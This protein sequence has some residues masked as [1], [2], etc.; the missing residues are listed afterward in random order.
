MAVAAVGEGVVVLVAVPGAGVVVRRAPLAHLASAPALLWLDDEEA[1]VE[2]VHLVSDGR[3]A[4]ALLDGGREVR[5]LRLRPDG[6]WVPQ[7]AR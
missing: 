5:A 6:S 4:V 2:R 7:R 3:G 1:P